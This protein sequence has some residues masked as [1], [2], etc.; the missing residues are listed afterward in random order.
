MRS[1]LSHGGGQKLND[2]QIVALSRNGSLVFD[3]AI[4][5]HWVQSFL[6]Q[7]MENQLSP[8]LILGQLV[9]VRMPPCL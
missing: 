7:W 3:I 2:R 9:N 4:C 8:L 5:L 6:I 1:R